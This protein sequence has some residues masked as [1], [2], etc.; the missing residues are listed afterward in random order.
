MTSPRGA[1]LR[2]EP[3]ATELSVD[4]VVNNH[5][6]E[7][8]VTAAVDSALAQIYPRVRV[9]V[10]DDGS[11]DDSRNVLSRY[12]QRVEL[13]LKENG[14]QASAL[15]AGFLR[16]KADI[17]IFLDADDVLR[18]NA[19]ALV[20]ATFAADRQI[21]KTQYRMEVIDED[22][23]RTGVIKP[24]SHL[25]LPQ[26]DVRRQEMVF[27]FDL[28]WLPT[29]G[30]AFR[31]ETLR[32]ILPIPER[33]FAD[34]PDW[35]LVHLSPL[36]G[37]V[38][39]LDEICAEYRIH[40]HNRYEPAGPTL[41]LDHV[42]QTVVYSAATR[43]ALDRLTEFL[44]LER[45]YREILSV[46][47]LSNR[48]VSL[49]LEREKHPLSADNAWS[50]A[51]QGLRA[52]KRRWDV[53]WPLKALFVCWFIAT[54]IVPRALVH[55]LAVGLMFPQRRPTLNRFLGHGHRTTPVG[56]TSAVRSDV[57]PL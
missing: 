18:P 30:N 41:D 40:G 14:G 5:N 42:R 1:A 10:V 35:Y 52:A 9:I 33:D 32:R 57:P 38:V 37:P 4:I 13:I 39:S 46:A 54:A 43:C 2:T 55:R 6:Y 26:G 56:H 31:A 15:N 23:S 21:V 36:F 28:V 20:A 16:S 50:I 7:R 24:P 51:V 19:A 17:V 12:D 11:T 48:L 53:S 34:C 3:G 8:F 47:D 44:G 25:P 27:P 29:S 22:G 49:R 45:P